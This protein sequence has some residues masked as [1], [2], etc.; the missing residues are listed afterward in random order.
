VLDETANAAGTGFDD[1]EVPA[2]AGVK[3]R[4]DHRVRALCAFAAR[5]PHRIRAG[6]WLHFRGR[7]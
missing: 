6:F 1:G 3:A 2:R 4:R 5:F 7:H